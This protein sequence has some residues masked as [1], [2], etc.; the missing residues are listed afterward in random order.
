MELTSALARG[1]TPQQ[2]VPR[3]QDRFRVLAST[4]RDL[5]PRQ[6]SM[7]GAI[8]WSYD[9]LSEDE[10]AL[11]AELSVFAGGFDLE[12]A[13]AVCETPGVFDLVYALRDKSLL[14]QCGGGGRSAFCHAGNPARLCP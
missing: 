5:D 14:A 8:D 9:L 12:A 6:R 7:R 11:F 13:E 1:M 2:I 10:R 4:R 3:L